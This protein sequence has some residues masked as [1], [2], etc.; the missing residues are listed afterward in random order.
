MEKKGRG[1]KGVTVLYDVQGV[2]GFADFCTDLK[3]KMGTGGTVKG[4]T[5][6]IQG[7]MRDRLRPL[8]QKMGF[9]VKG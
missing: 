6:E 1:G 8:L 7:D 3:K 5:I 9:Q 4:N 2:V